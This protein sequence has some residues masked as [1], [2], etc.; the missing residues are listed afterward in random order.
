MGYLGQVSKTGKNS[1]IMQIPFDYCKVKINIRSQSLDLWKLPVGSKAKQILEESGLCVI[2]V[3][4]P[5]G[6]VHKSPNIWM[7]VLVQSWYSLNVAC[8]DLLH[9]FSFSH[10]HRSWL[11]MW[12]T[13]YWSKETGIPMVSHWSAWRPKNDWSSVSQK[14]L[15]PYLVVPKQ[16]WLCSRNQSP[17][18]WL[19]SIIN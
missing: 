9:P 5:K 15:V 3:V 13:C 7:W 2:Q 10:R 14:A 16:T 17:V 8:G 18:S 19:L 4:K 11:M 6:R 1:S 12:Y